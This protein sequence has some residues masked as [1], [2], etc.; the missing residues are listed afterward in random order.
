MY[1]CYY[2]PNNNN[3]NNNNN[4]HKKYTQV[5]HVGKESFH[6]RSCQECIKLNR[7][8]DEF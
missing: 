5:V 6:Q 7:E 8:R 2:I 3:N 1:L 4:I